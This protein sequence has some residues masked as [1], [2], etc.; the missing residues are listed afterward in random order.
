MATLTAQEY[1]PAL[2]VTMPPSFESTGLAE[3][4]EKLRA[5]TESLHDRLRA[6]AGPRVAPYVLL[7]AHRR[8]VLWRVSARELYHVAR[9]RCDAHAQWDIRRMCDAA[10]SLARERIPSLLLLA[11]G[12]DRFE[13]VRRSVFP[14]SA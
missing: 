8:R 3:P 11:C 1:D 6:A 12:K 2:G 14:E 13:E 4:F 5:S 10:I 9:L 7:N